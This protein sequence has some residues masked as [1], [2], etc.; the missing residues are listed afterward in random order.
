MKSVLLLISSLLFRV[1]GGFLI[2]STGVSPPGESVNVSLDVSRIIRRVDPRFLSVT[3]DASLA[4]DEKFMFLL[5]SPKLRTLARA[6]TPAFLRFGGTQQDFM[7]FTP[8]FTS[9]FTAEK[10]CNELELPSWL[11]EKLTEEWSQQEMLLMSEDRKKKFNRTTYTESTVDLLNSFTNCTG[12]DLIFGVNALLRTAD[13]SWNSSNARLL[14]QYCESR[15][16]RMSWELG[17]EPNSFR[18][19]S[20]IWV[21]GLQ[22]GQDFTHFRQIMSKSKFYHNAQLYGPDIGQPR[23]HRTDL[24]ESFL[25]SGANAINAFTWHHYYVNGRDTSLKDFLDPKLLDVLKTK[26]DEVLERVKQVSPGKPVWLGE[27]S[28]AYGGGAERLSNTFVAGFMWLD[29]LG[30][31]ARLGIDVVMRQSLIG[32]GRY[33]L[34]DN[35]L[36]PLPD[37]WL[38]VLY[39]RLVG[40][41]VLGIK[42][43]S[44]FGRGKTVRLYLHCTNKRSYGDGAVTMI[45]MNL[46]KRPARI[47][48][49]AHVS[50]STVDAFVLQSEKPGEEGLHSSSVKLNGQVLKMVDDKTLPDLKGIRLPAAEHLELPAYSLAFYVLTDARAAACQT[51]H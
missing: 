34:V 48:M 35:Q 2:N 45:S 1:T 17:N 40:P 47:S 36:E 5:S 7:V 11:E 24:L 22:L 9:S 21:D 28:S 20:G 32:N 30:L 15:Q 43:L 10:S 25:H 6:L 12:L 42:V 23:T 13:N 27:T 33:N 18:W 46:S 26:T 29:K 3:V 31:A 49:P 4:T 44:I 19:K 41:E 37:Y 38:S 51:S 8:Q 39:K 14:M 50:S 16:Y